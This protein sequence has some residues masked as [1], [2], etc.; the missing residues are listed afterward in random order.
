[1]RCRIVTRAGHRASL[2]RMLVTSALAIPI[3]FA[4]GEARAQQTAETR[5]QQTDDSIDFSKARE[6]L[7]RTR[8]GQKLTAEEQAF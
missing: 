5:E 3:I 7:R 8:L 6:I 4:I 1:M 2:V